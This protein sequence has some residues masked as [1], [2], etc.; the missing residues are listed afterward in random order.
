MKMYI[1]DFETV[2][3]EDT[4]TQTHTEVWAWGMAQLF[5]NTERVKIGNS[6]DSFFDY[7]AT[8]GKHILV[9]FI[10]LK[11][12]GS[13]IIDDLIR[14]KGYRNGFDAIAEEFKKSKDL[15]DKEVIYTI[16]DMGMWYSIVIKYKGH[17]IE[18]RD[19]LKLLPFSVK[20]LSKAFD[21]KYK[22]LEMDYKGHSKSG[23]VITSQ[24]REYIRNDILVPKEAFEKFL[25]EMN[26]QKNPPMTIASGALR[27]YKKEYT[28]QQWDL[29]FPNLAEVELL[30]DDYGSNN[31]DEYIRK[32][33]YGGWCF[34]NP[35]YA[36]RIVGKSKTN[37][38][39]CIK[40]A[41]VNSLYPS[42]MHSKS[43]TRYPVGLPTFFK[44][45]SG[46]N[47]PECYYF[48]RFRCNFEL[49]KG[50][51][52]FIQIKNNVNYRRNENLISS[53]WT[54]DGE[55]DETIR[56]EMTM[57]ET[58]FSLFKKCYNL[59]DFELLDGCYFETETGIFDGYVDKYMTMKISYNDNV[60]K[61]T[62]A[63]L[64]LNN[65]YGRFSLNPLNAFKVC[66]E[67]DDVI[68][69]DI[70]Q[71]E[72]K[73][74][75]FIPIGC[76][77]TS[78]ARAFTVSGAI[79]NYDTFAYADTDSLHMVCTQD[80]EPKGIRLHDTDLCAWKL[81]NVWDNGLYLRQKTYIEYTGDKY[82]VKACGLSQRSKELLV[83][84]F[85]GTEPE[86]MTKEEKIFVHK[87]RTV[88]D[89]K[90]GLTIPSNLEPKIITGGCVLV[91][92]SF[93]IM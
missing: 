47:H 81:E 36:D 64:L 58:M 12:D 54:R 23:E 40:V 5:D 85:N 34:V 68:E 61:R 51:L 19:G 84:S 49:K 46:L 87:K 21:T 65:L 56:P 8:L 91:E 69:M 30:K 7:C 14:N 20:A 57:S 6:I 18:F 53:Y 70:H 2:V 24:E 74:P 88:R 22:K 9:Y 44:G 73:K 41:D 76:A 16:S 26:W 11:F 60:V 92:T 59:K 72:D 63:K 35:R 48:I 90:Q 27:E 93:T 71:G 75:L 13:F 77:I 42:V 39:G 83:H 33:Y 10:N 89:F 1:A 43:G 3:E 86:T 52:P 62:C 82:D 79:A 67:F 32:A 55:F 25:T 38:D 45:R 80:Y 37:K 50:Y 31:V 28:P 15:Q 78:Y 66:H 29:W 17:L 4:K